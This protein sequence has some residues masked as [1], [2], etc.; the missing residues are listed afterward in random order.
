MLVIL[1]AFGGRETALKA[2]EQLA[3][4]NEQFRQKRDIAE[5]EFAKFSTNTRRDHDNTE[6]ELRGREEA[7]SK[8]AADAKTKREQVERRRLAEK[9]FNAIPLEP[10][11]KFS[12]SLSRVHPRLEF[13]DP[14]AKMKELVRNNDLLGLIN[15]I[16]SYSPMGNPGFGL[17]GRGAGFSAGSAAVPQMQDKLEILPDEGTI[18]DLAGQL[19]NFKFTL[20]VKTARTINLSDLRRIKFRDNATGS[21][22][23]TWASDWEVHPD[24]S[25]FICPWI[26][27]D[28]DM[29]LVLGNFGTLSEFLSQQTA[30]LTMQEQALV[31]K[32]ELGE[33]DRKTADEQIKSARRKAR[34]LIEKRALV[35]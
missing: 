35:L 33:L 15:C 6:V 32:V 16:D 5:K 24:G 25:G 17:T 18:R 27:S 8:A 22:A 12:R 13:R 14:F 28:G 9:I 19:Q 34:Q 29:I 31:R 26:P 1:E 30:Q 7:E 2:K 23:V 3:A 11:I 4:I 20:V 10:K 21:D